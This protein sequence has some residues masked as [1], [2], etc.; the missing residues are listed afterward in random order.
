MP[1]ASKPNTR[2]GAPPS[3]EGA[4]VVLGSASARRHQVLRDL[5][6]PFEVAVADV[7]EMLD[8]ADP[9]ATAAANARRKFDALRVRF[10]D[11]WLLTAD[12]V[13]FIGGRVLGKPVDF[14]DG[15]RMLLSYSGAVQLVVTAMVFAAPGGPPEPREAVSSLRFREITESEARDYLRRF[16]TTD[17]AGAYDLESFHFAVESIGGSASN[18]RGLPRDVVADWFR[19]HAA[20]AGWVWKG[21]AAPMAQVDA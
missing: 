5:G 7:P 16:G 15:V 13:V 11:R 12:T 21:F 4:V 17:R 1:S 3:G 19:A 2:D 18:I 6:I 20:F 9:V 14:E 10:P 8:P